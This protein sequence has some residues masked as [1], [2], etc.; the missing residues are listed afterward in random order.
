LTV[1]EGDTATNATVYY[2]LGTSGWGP[3][4][5]GL[6]TALWGLQLKYAFSPPY[7]ILYWPAGSTS[8]SLEVSTNLSDLNA[9]TQVSNVFM[10]DGEDE[11]VIDTAY[12]LGFFRLKH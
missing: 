10:V 8:L 9:W 4:F 2:R 5:G 3:T 6:P 12:G 7:L 1:F 11:A